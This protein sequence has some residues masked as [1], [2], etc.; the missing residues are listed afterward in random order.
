[1]VMDEHPSIRAKRRMVAAS[2]SGKAPTSDMMKMPGRG[3]KRGHDED[4]A[5]GAGYGGTAVY[6]QQRARPQVAAGDAGDDGPQ[7]RRRPRTR[8]VP[9]RDCGVTDGSEE[10]ASLFCLDFARGCCP[11]GGEC[12]HRH[13]VASVVD[14]LNEACLNEEYDVFGRKRSL[15]LT[16]WEKKHGKKEAGSE[17]LQNKTLHVSGLQPPAKQRTA[18]CGGRGGGAKSA[19]G[20]TDEAVRAC[21]GAFGSVVETNVRLDAVAT[22]PNWALV[23]FDSRASAEVAKEA[24]TGQSLTL[25]SAEILQIRFAEQDDA[26]PGANDGAALQGYLKAL[27][28]APRPAPEAALPAG[29]TTA[30]DETGRVYFY[31]LE[32]RTTQW[33][34]PRAAPIAPPAPPLAPLE[35]EGLAAGWSLVHDEKQRL[36]YYHHAETG[37]TQW[38]K[39][40]E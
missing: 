28:P 34:A 38:D 20:A 35:P 27:Q 21:F 22:R 3:S 17:D 29:W 32:S 31:N 18:F 16:A 9:S 24:M 19:K 26:A 1:M 15:L 36:V 4:E 13:D 25:Q 23:T 39:P 11:D 30:R 10:G 5:P 37:K 6:A 14:D 33:H 12:T 8:C 40:T 7:L 2:T